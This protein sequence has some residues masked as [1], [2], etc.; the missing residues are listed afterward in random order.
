MDLAVVSAWAY[1]ISTT[2]RAWSFEMIVG[3]IWSPQWR[4]AVGLEQGAQQ[5]CT[6]NPRCCPRWMVNN[7]CASCYETFGVCAVGCNLF[8][9]A[10]IRWISGVLWM[11]TLL[12]FGVEENYSGCLSC[13]GNYNYMDYYDCCR[14][15]LFLAAFDLSMFCMR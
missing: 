6:A 8:G 12:G 14:L 7:D 9:L 11:C 2:V 3:S 13:H 15:H 10:G 1:L 5:G 4:A